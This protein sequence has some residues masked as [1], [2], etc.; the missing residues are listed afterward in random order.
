MIALNVRIAVTTIP[1]LLLDLHLSHA[2]GSF[3]VTVPVLCFGL[4]A[5][6]GPRLR[7]RLGDERAILLSSAGLVTGS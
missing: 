3:L 1:P 5:P 7:S 2:A 4:A 6:F